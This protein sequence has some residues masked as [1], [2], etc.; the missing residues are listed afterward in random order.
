MCQWKIAAITDEESATGMVDGVDEHQLKRKIGKFNL[1]EDSLI[2][3][4]NFC[5]QDPTQT[6][7]SQ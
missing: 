2:N 1:E 7:M 6:A 5:Y 3:E 4:L